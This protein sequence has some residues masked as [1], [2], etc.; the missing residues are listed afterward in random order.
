MNKSIFFKK[1]RNIQAAWNGFERVPQVPFHRP[2]CSGSMYLLPC[3]NYLCMP[4]H[5]APWKLAQTGSVIS[6]RA[7]SRCGLQLPVRAWGSVSPVR[8]W[9]RQE[10]LCS[11]Y[12][13]SQS[14]FLSQQGLGLLITS[15]SV[16]CFGHPWCPH[17]GNTSLFFLT[18]F[19]LA[20]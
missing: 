14:H 11:W 19:S 16:V 18:V 1:E 20:T 4:V 2:C 5:Q 17:S 7:C 12:Y 6:N 9:G 15:L 3:L 10:T 13:K 8:G